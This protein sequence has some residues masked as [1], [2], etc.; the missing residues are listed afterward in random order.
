MYKL[1]FSILV[2]ST[3]FAGC[4]P[5]ADK[6]IVVKVDYSP[7]LKRLA[8]PHNLKFR[9]VLEA[10]LDKNPKEHLAKA[11]FKNAKRMYPNEKFR[12]YFKW[13]YGI[14]AGMSNKKVK[15]II[16]R[17]CDEAMERM[18][19]NMNENLP[20]KLV[21]VDVE[22]LNHSKLK[23]LVQTE[24]KDELIH[25]IFQQQVEIGFYATK[26]IHDLPHLINHIELAL[27]PDY[28]IDTMDLEDTSYQFNNIGTIQQVASI[29]NELDF[30][31]NGR[32]MYAKKNVLDELL[33]S[34]NQPKLTN[35][36][37]LQ[38]FAEQKAI[39]GQDIVRIHCCVVKPL[40]GKALTG[41]S[42][43]SAMSQ[44][45]SNYN[46]YV[47]QVR[48]NSIGSEKFARLTMEEMGNTIAI[49]LNGKVISAPKVLE[50]IRG[51][52]V[53]I[54]GAF[55]E[56]D[57]GELATLLGKRTSSLPCKVLSIKDI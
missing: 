52:T 14:K 7:V 23:I 55:S 28:E 9:E 56:K 57:A 37:R 35:K 38:F 36:G 53:Q 16:L 13:E 25:K 48:F 22:Q 19:D 32:E 51:G 45:E 29:W 6:E 54:S 4:S 21:V 30:D 26:N 40:K 20:A 17:L 34:L 11:F 27:A 12:N 1:L 10:T 24:L 47:V 31:Q 41:S 15:E 33:D 3:V 49:V 18:V 50:P 39:P 2:L 42:I 43:K 46:E 44:F 5:N 8:R